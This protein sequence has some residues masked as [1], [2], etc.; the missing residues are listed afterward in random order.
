MLMSG[1]VQCG[2]CVCM[3]SCCSVVHQTKLSRLKTYCY[4][5]NDM[6]YIGV[7]Y[8]R[9]GIYRQH[10]NVPKRWKAILASCW[11]SAFMGMSEIAG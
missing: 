9:C 5:R 3:G 1:R 8:V 7:V 6:I 2:H 4:N 11:L 10:T